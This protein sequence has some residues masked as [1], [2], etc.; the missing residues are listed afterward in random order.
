MKKVFLIFGALGML[1]VFIWFIGWLKSAHAQY[2][3]KDTEFYSLPIASH[4]LVNL[5]IPERVTIDDRSPYAENG[6]LDLYQYTRYSYEDDMLTAKADYDENGSLLQWTMWEYD[7]AGNVYIEQ[8]ENAAGGIQSYA[9]FYEYDSSGKCVHE[10]VYRNEDLM[11][12]NYFRHTD[13]GRAGV[14]YLYPDKQSDLKISGSS[15]SCTEFLEDQEGNTLC[16]LGFHYWDQEEPDEVWKMEWTQQNSQIVNRVRYYKADGRKLSITRN[17]NREYQEDWYLEREHADTEQV[18]LYEYNPETGVG[19]PILQLNYEWQSEQYG[20]CLIPSFYRAQYDGD[21]LLW[22]M[23]YSDG[24]LTHYSAYQYDTDGQLEI[25]IEYDTEKEKTYALLHRYEYPEDDIMEEYVY[26]IQ[27]QE[28]SHSFGDGKNVQLT[29][30]KTDILIGI[31]MTDAAGTVL[32]KY[33]FTEF[34]INVGKLKNMHMG[35]DIITGEDAVLEKLEEKAG[36]E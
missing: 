18:N 6:M 16:V 12:D 3:R 13:I 11:E 32:E 25:V 27:E 30:S 34:D 10:E 26:E 33:E 2:K 29:Y 21:R 15:I 5:H 22:Q 14:S 28:F 4:T 31:E 8:T 17:S 20:F 19:N 36:A 1:L 35:T 24:R 7:T 9:H 23:L